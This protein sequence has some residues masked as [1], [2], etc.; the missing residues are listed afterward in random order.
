MQWQLLYKLISGVIILNKKVLVVDDEPNIL[1]LLDYNLKK[2]GYD[3]ILADT[4]EKALALVVTEKP[5]IILLDQ[6]LPGIDGLAVLRKIR[7][8]HELGDIPVIIVTA[9]CEEIDKIVGL[10]LGADDYMTKPFSVRELSARIKANLRRSIVDAH[11]TMNDIIHEALVIDNTNY[12]VFI[13]EIEIKMT[14]KEFELL[15]MLL[16]NKEKVLTRDAILNKVWGYKYY[17]G[18]RTVD[19]HIT[20]IRRKIE[21]YGNNIETIRGVGYRFKDE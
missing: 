12:K 9:K 16:S 19:V 17:G 18:T 8:M 21:Q 7:L 2:D 10:D 13:D 14:L 15:R 1:E 3:V 20:N 6:M 11:L 4:G 5:D